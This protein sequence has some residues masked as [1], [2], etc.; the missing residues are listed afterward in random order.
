V[1]GEL[2]VVGVVAL[3]LEEAG[4]A[5]EFAVE[6][7]DEEVDG[8]VK[9]VGGDGDDEFG[10]VEDDVAFGEEFAGVV[11]GGGV[12]EFDAEAVEAGFVFKEA[13]HFGVDGVLEGV[14]EFEVD[15]GQDEIVVA[16]RLVRLLV[17][18]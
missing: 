16:H 7:V 2:D 1:G 17:M 15:A 14:G 3:D 5:A 18:G 6:F 8:L 10:A 11:L 13:F 4:A 9:V 12:F